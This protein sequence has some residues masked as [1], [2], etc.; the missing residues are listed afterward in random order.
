MFVGKFNFS[1][2]C[3]NVFSPA[4]R[5]VPNRPA[6]KSGAAGGGGVL[7]RGGSGGGGGGGGGQPRSLQGLAHQNQKLDKQTS[8]FADRHGDPSPRKGARST[9]R[10]LDPPKGV[11]RGISADPQMRKSEMKKHSQPHPPQPPPPKEKTPQREVPQQPHPH[12]TVDEPPVE[13]IVIEEEPLARKSSKERFRSVVNTKVASVTAFRRGIK[14][15]SVTFSTSTPP[16]KSASQT[17]L[18][19]LLRAP[20]ESLDSSRSLSDESIATKPRR[21]SLPWH[22]ETRPKYKRLLRK[23]IEKEP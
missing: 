20:K 19:D 23:K 11:K 17:S 5:D 14:T 3:S 16:A 15:R 4:F 22:Y 8:L 13:V 1:R 12:L 6:D 18:P 21:E 9:K 7:R 2:V 10:Q